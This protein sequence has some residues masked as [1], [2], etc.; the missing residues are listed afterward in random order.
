MLSDMMMPVLDLMTNP[1][2]LLIVFLLAM[3]FAMGRIVTTNNSAFSVQEL[4]FDR[5]KG[6]MSSE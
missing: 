4:N 3:R 6:S 5:P 1:L 2:V